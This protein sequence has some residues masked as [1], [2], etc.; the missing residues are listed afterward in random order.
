MKLI[1]SIVILLFPAWLQAQDCNLKKTT[2]PYT[3]EV[4]LSTGLIPFKGASL[5]IEADSKEIDFFFSMDAKEKCFNDA[6]TLGILYEGTKAKAS[7]RN[8]GPMNCDGFFHIIF[9]NGELT[10]TLLQRLTTQKIVSL[11][12]TDSNKALTTLTLSP[13]EQQK[14]ITSG[15]CLVRDAKTLLK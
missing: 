6:S 5:S 11:V 15:T 13:E 4:R 7:F 3:K 2:D 9:K 12:F 10:P 8:G 1:P 14:M